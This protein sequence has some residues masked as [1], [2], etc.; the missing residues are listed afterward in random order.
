MTYLV[1]FAAP[2]RRAL[3]EQLPEAVAA[4]A[5]ELCLGG[6]AENPRRV[7]KQ[8]RPP[9]ADIW[10]ARRGDYRV[11]YSI[12]EDEQR[13]VVQAVEHRRDAYR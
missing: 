1:E 5:L 6:L 9:L 8:L 2:A 4:A 12:D 13:V 10:S 11:L 3:S 7:G